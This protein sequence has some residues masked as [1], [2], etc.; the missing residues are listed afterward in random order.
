MNE[1]EYLD[2]STLHPGNYNQELTPQEQ[3]LLQL[4][5]GLPESEKIN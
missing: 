5:R 3:A 2:E 4:F 1:G